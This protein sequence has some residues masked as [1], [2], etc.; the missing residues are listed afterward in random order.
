[1]TII[2]TDSYSIFII[3][4]YSQCSHLIR[5]CILFLTGIPLVRDTSLAKDSLY[6]IAC[7]YDDSLDCGPVSFVCDGGLLGIECIGELTR[8]H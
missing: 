3:Y 1:M 6:P 8:T 4:S 2:T 5:H 7:Q